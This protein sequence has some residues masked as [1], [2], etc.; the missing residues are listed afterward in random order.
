MNGLPQSSEESAYAS[1]KNIR[2][3]EDHSTR[4]QL[5]NAFDRMLIKGGQLQA[6]IALMTRAASDAGVIPI[7]N[8]TACQLAFDLSSELL[9]AM[10]DALNAVN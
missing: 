7:Y 9:A 8:A 6:L 4:Q 1:P 10:T 2:D 3:E 5:N